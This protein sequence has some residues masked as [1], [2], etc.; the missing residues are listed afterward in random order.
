MSNVQISTPFNISLD[1]EI[2]PF[3]KRL[4]AT[5]LDLTLMVAYASFMRFILYDALLLDGEKAMGIDIL[6]VSVP[7]F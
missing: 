1:F 3:F 2:A 4:V 7:F 6:V 5:L